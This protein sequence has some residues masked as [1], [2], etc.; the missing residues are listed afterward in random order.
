MNQRDIEK[1]IALKISRLATAELAIK[2]HPDTGWKIKKGIIETAGNTLSEALDRAIDGDAM[3]YRANSGHCSTCGHYDREVRQNRHY[4][5]DRGT[6][7]IHSRKRG[8]QVFVN[9]AWTCD[10]YIQRDQL[11]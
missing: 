5:C 9:P 10:D 3:N 8:A 4:L 6:C 2:Y 7:P 1:Y 11:N